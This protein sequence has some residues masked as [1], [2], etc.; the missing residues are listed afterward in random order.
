MYNKHER[1][2]AE[3]VDR[4]SGLLNYVGRNRL[5]LAPLMVACY[6][7]L[8]GW[9]LARAPDVGPIP[10]KPWVWPALQI[11]GCFGAGL[12]ARFTDT[13]SADVVRW[14]GIVLGL[15]AVIATIL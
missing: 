13:L 6:A 9:M 15:V 8:I 7:G 3:T 14:L 2:T 4:P 10:V 1:A 12:G 11:V 5:W